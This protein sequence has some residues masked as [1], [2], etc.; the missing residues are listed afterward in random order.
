MALRLTS[1]MRLAHCSALVLQMGMAL[2]F[3]GQD[4]HTI[5]RASIPSPTILRYECHDYASTDC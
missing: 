4:P 5:D 3:S 2:D 1:M